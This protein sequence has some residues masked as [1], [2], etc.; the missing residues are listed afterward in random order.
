MKKISCCSSN[1]PIQSREPRALHPG[2]GKHRNP[3]DHSKRLLCASSCKA[4]CG[5]TKN[6]CGKS[7]G[8]EV[9]LDPK[10]CGSSVCPDPE[11]TG[12]QLPLTTPPQETHS[13]PGKMLRTAWSSREKNRKFAQKP[14]KSDHD[15]PKIT[16]NAGDRLLEHGRSASPRFSISPQVQRLQ[17][18]LSAVVSI[19][20]LVQVLTSLEI[21]PASC[22]SADK[23]IPQILL[24][25]SHTV[26][27]TSS[28]KSSLHRC[29]WPP[30]L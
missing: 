22:P 16:A 19:T 28:P 1:S 10:S 9:S 25:C 5:Q 7:G 15:I 24:G 6:R 11:E 21:H 29:S 20:N 8:T 17:F 14:D 2:S 18:G 27:A 13:S 3:S 4:R 12:R 23:K 30:N 26:Q